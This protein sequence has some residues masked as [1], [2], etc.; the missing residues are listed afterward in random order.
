MKK[1]IAILCVAVFLL[2]F[3]PATAFA[4]TQ[5]GSPAGTAFVDFTTGDWAATTTG[6]DMPAGWTATDAT[7]T[8][9]GQYVAKL[10]FTGTDAGMVAD[11]TQF[12][13]LVLV[14]GNVDFPGY[15]IKIDDIKVNGASVPM[16][17]KNYTSSDDK[18]E[19]RSNI[20]NQWVPSLPDDA[21][22]VDGDTSTASPEIID[23]A[24]AL[25]GTTS[26]EVD[27]TFYDADGNDG[28]AVATDTT[29]TDTTTTTD[30]PKTGVVGLGIV[31]GLGAL[32]T[33]SF[34]LKRKSK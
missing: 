34:V 27:F 15:F 13:A 22:C 14:N 28:S 33:G 19:M 6:T 7:V 12:L 2:S 20:W 29:A 9:P 31:Y 16:S 32:A 26:I 21:R 30:V 18:I 23:P 3:M 25:V 1:V 4:G 5:G 8:G 10:D 11:G 24:T 17:A